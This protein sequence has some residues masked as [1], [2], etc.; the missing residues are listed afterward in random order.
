MIRPKWWEVKRLRMGLHI[1]FLLYSCGVLHGFSE[2]GW[3]WLPASVPLENSIRANIS[4][5]GEV[6]LS[7]KGM[8]AFC[9]GW[10]FD[11]AQVMGWAFPANPRRDVEVPVGPFP[12]ELL[13]C[14]RRRNS[15]AEQDF[16]RVASKEKVDQYAS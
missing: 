15:P 7:A 4:V 10:P 5:E 16:R 12:V 14:L 2:Y 6:S 8:L 13:T 3:G 1:E 9:A 11:Q